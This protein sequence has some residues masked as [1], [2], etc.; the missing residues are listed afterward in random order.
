MLEKAKSVLKEE[1]DKIKPSEAVA[2]IYIL[3]E[4]KK[5]LS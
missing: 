3:E 5:S 4:D 1:T 2:A